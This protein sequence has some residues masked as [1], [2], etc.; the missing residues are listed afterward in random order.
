MARTTHRK[1]NNGY[2][3]IVSSRIDHKIYMDLRFS[4]ARPTISITAIAEKNVPGAA[5]PAL[6]GIKGE[7]AIRDP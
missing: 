5:Y 4:R 6:Y 1:T 2:F 7:N 3:T